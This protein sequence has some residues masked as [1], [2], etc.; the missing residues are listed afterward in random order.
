LV[1]FPEVS[2]KCGVNQTS[3]A[4]G[5]VADGT[6]S[7][8]ISQSSRYNCDEESFVYSYYHSDQEYKCSHC[9]D[10]EEKVKEN[11]IVGYKIYPEGIKPDKTYKERKLYWQQFK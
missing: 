9:N 1:I 2:T 8:G 11:L 7:R 3:E 4:S 6:C 5:K 10:H